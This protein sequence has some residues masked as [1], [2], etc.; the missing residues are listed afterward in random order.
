MAG[1]WHSRLNLFLGAQDG[2]SRPV[3]SARRA[4]RLFISDLNYASNQMK[5]LTEEGLKVNKTIGSLALES[6]RSAADI[7]KMQSSIF[8]LS[9]ATG[10][11]IDTTTKLALALGNVGVRI[12]DLTTDSPGEAERLVDLVHIFGLSAEKAAELEVSADR[13]GTTIKHLGN[14]AVVFGKEFGVVGLIGQLP[15]AT[16]FAMTAV[17]KF[18]KSIV[19]NE[20]DIAINTLKAG[21]AF[22]RAFRVDAGT[23]LKMAQ[24]NFEHF[25]GAMQETRNVFLGLSTDFPPLVK[26]LLVTGRSVPNIMDMLSMA[27][28]PDKALD[29]VIKMQEEVKRIAKYSPITAMQFKEQIKMNIP[30]HLRAIFESESL[31][32]DAIN[33]RN[34]QQRIANRNSTNGIGTFNELTESIKGL[35]GPSMELFDNLWGLSK[36]LIGLFVADDIKKIFGGSDG[37]GGLIGTIRGWNTEIKTA[38]DTLKKDKGFAHLRT[39]AQSIVK[40]LILAGKGFGVI[41]AGVATLAAARVFLFPLRLGLAAISKV[42]S[43]AAIPFKLL[44]GALNVAGAGAGF[45]TRGVGFLVNGAGQLISHGGRLVKFIGGALAGSIHGLGTL[46]T[47]G[48][49]IFTFFGNTGRLALRGIGYA[50]GQPFVLAG[51]FMGVLNSGARYGLVRLESIRSLLTRLFNPGIANRNIIQLR[52]LFRFVGHDAVH[53]AGKLTTIFGRFVKLPFQLMGG[54]SGFAGRA[55]AWVTRGFGGFAKGIGSLTGGLTKLAGG[56]GTRIGGV[57]AKLGSG[58]GVIGS[59]VGKVNIGALDRKSVV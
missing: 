35:A 16:S 13:L 32:A 6:G 29:F 50:F 49:G 12:D 48:A 57:V 41:A 31:T 40:W 5:N 45:L 51:K 7:D 28:D 27:K 1:R 34:E 23:G 25:A 9:N 26:T 17:G 55:A 52:K 19:G 3:G 15:A 46:I 20:K 39:Q 10:A 59:V 2:V 37:N 14:K 18:S 11:S 22:S 36:A 47:K 4:I 44:G 8:D 56:L 38:L 24:Q 43:I 30:E 53:W 21:A 42:A 58:F 33:A 54:A